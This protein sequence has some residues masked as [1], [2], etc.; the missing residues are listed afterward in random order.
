M[1]QWNPLWPLAAREGDDTAMASLIAHFMPLVRR[2][3]R[4]CTCPGLDFED[5]VQEGLIGLLQAVRC[6]KADID[7]RPYAAACVRNAQRSARRR[8]GRK[9][10]SPLNN[11]IPLT[12]STPVP[13]PEQLILEREA[14]F[15]ALERFSSELSGLERRV[16]R[17]RIQGLRTSAIAGRLHISS[18]AAENALSRARR[19]LKREK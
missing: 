19:K 9:K 3:A 18:K 4:E 10:N 7:F 2:G 13:G 11:S 1:R 5:A 16:L 14:C 12:D 17:L 8:A 6:C 15:D